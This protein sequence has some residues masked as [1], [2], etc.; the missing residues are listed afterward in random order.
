VRFISNKGITDP[1]VNLALE[2]YCLRNLYAQGPFI[3]FYVN[4]PSVII[5]RNQNLPVEADTAWARKKGIHVI[6]RLSGGGAVYHEAGNLNFSFI[7]GFD[8]AH[9]NNYKIF[10]APFIRALNG[11]G[12]PAA[13]NG[14]NDIQVNGKKISGNAQYSTGRAILT[15]GTLLFDARLDALEKVLAG[16]KGATP[17]RGRPSVRSPVVNILEILDY[18]MSM[19]DFR[20]AMRDAAGQDWNA[21]GEYPLSP[22]DWEQVSTLA[23]EKYASWDWNMGHSPGFSVRNTCQRP[24]GPVEIRLEVER[25]I[26]RDVWTSGFTQYEKQSVESLLTGIYYKRKAVERALAGFDPVLASVICYGCFYESPLA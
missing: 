19:N 4:D 8:P 3:L 23:R 22:A 25:G 20:S 24:K 10:T 12:V 21:A 26:I 16:D 14:R 7:T 17:V 13:L 2:E 5:G 15:H 9:L 11:M 18:P 1:R 6:R